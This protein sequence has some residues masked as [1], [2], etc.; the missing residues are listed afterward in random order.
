MNPLFTFFELPIATF[1]I[2]YILVL[3]FKIVGI[4]AITWM[5]VLILALLV[6]ICCAFCAC[7]IAMVVHYWSHS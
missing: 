4:I 2:T 3:T 5:P 1:I 7:V 6:G